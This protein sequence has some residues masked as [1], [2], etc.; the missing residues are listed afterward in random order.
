MAMVPMR[1]ILNYRE[2]I[3]MC[4]MRFYGHLSDIR[5]TVFPVGKKQAVPVQR[6]FFFKFIVNLYFGNIA[7][8]K[9]QCRHGYLPVYG[10]GPL[11]P[12][13]IVDEGITY[14]EIV[15]HHVLSPV[16][17]THLTLPTIYS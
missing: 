14:M 17:Y 12:A 11:F 4:R 10:N 6:C 9:R 3:L 1:T 8:C 13:R 7:F 2:S 15:A 16:S 5:H